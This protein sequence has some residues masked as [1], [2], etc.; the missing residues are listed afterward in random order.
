MGKRIYKTISLERKNAFYNFPFVA[1]VEKLRIRYR[2]K[3]I[4]V[5]IDAK[6]NHTSKALISGGAQ[7][8]DIMSFSSDPEDCC[9]N[10]AG[11]IGVRKLCLTARQLYSKLRPRQHIVVSHDGQQIPHKTLHDLEPLFTNKHKT[12]GLMINMVPRGTQHANATFHPDVVIMAEKNGYRVIEEEK[13]K[14]YCQHEDNKGQHMW[15]FW[16]VFERMK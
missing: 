16:F 14:S 11:R 2:H 15:P 5:V 1:R 6:R 7:P 8:V 3:F 9:P 10:E 12:I 4:Y 13:L